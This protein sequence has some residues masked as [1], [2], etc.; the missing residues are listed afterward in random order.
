MQLAD[1]LHASPILF[2]SLWACLVLLASAMGGGRSAALAPLSILGS[3]LGLLLCLWAWGQYEQPVTGVFAGMLVVDRFALFFDALFLLAATITFLLAHAYLAD[4]QFADG[5]FYGMLLLA[6]AGM[7]LMVHAG[8]AIA[9][10]IGLE[11]MSLAVYSLV[12]CWVEKRKSAEAGLKYFIMGAVASAFL[13]YGFALL[14]TLTG[15]MQLGPLAKA[16]PALASEPLAVIGML[17]VLGALAFKVA[18]VPFH[19]WTPDAYEGAPTPVTGFMAAAVKASGFAVLLRIVSSVFGDEAFAYGAS[20]WA[21]LFWTLAA[22]TMTLG[23]LLALGQNNIKRM[24]AYSSISHAGYLMLGV[25]A[26]ASMG[27]PPAP[28]LFYLLQYGLTTM[29]AFGVVSWLGRRGAE[30]VGLEDWGGLAARHPAAALA[31]TIFLLSLGGLP[32]M[33]GFF[34]KLYLF[35]AALEHP[36]LLTLVVI[37]ALNSVISI[38][39]Y[40]KPVVAMYFRQP[41]Q[42]G[43]GGSAVQGQAASWAT[44]TAAALALSVVCVLLLGIVPDASIRWAGQALMATFGG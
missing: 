33:S 1:L 28:V 12:A 10:V 5:E 9:L 41:S 23:N 21:S 18:L 8:D 37:A 39:Y 27:R 44:G 38:F 42:L 36:G 20:G 32:P 4:H 14:Y 26:S 17:M 13:L 40:L 31:M 15:Q 29:G 3:V 34:A 24:L 16:M 7:M 35:K 2:V 6:V 43:A 19:M 25:I 22:A 11:T 30:R